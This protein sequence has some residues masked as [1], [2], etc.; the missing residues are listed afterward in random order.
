MICDEIIIAAKSRA[1]YAEEVLCFMRTL[2]SFRVC[3]IRKII[4][5]INTLNAPMRAD[6]FLR[7]YTSSPM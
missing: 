4:I 5:P 3:L 1:L 6:Y 7:A 2:I